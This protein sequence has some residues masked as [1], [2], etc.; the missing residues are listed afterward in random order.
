VSHRT[1]ELLVGDAGGAENLVMNF[2]ACDLIAGPVEWQPQRL[3]LIWRC[4]RRRE[5]R[6]WEYTLK[7]DSVEFHVEA[8]VFAFGRNVDLID[9]ARQYAQ[10]HTRE[11]SVHE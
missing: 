9:E 10:I 1:F 11:L 6:V 3:E 8:L 7:D 5:H 4:D 2:E